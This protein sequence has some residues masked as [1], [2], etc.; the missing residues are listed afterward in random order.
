MTNTAELRD[1]LGNA[2]YSTIDESMTTTETATS[3]A[4]SVHGGDG[5]SAEDMAGLVAM[6]PAESTEAEDA[7]KGSKP[8]AT[9]PPWAASESNAAVTAAHP[10]G[11]EA[12]FGEKGGIR[13]VSLANAILQRVPLATDPGARLYSYNR[14]V[15]SLD[16]ERTVR[17]HT[18]DLLGDRYRPTHASL[19][20]SVITAR[21]PRISDDLITTR[22]INVANGL[23]DWKTGELHPHTPDVISINQL[24]VSWHPDATCPRITEWLR[25][26]MQADCL[27]L[28][29]EVLG[30]AIYPEL[31]WQKAVMLY[32]PGGNGKG[33]FLRLVESLTGRENVAN[34]GP[35]SLDEKRFA[36][37]EL[38]GKLV[39]IAGDVDPKA[40]KVTEMFKMVTGGDSITAEF[41]YGQPFRFVNRSLM[42]CSFNAFPRT[43][44]TSD[45]FFRRWVVL[46]FLYKIMNRDSSVED[47][48]HTTEELQGLLAM[49]VRGLQRL[50]RRGE[51]QEPASVREIT[52]EFKRKA[53]PVRSW[54]HDRTIGEEGHWLSRNLL[55]EDYQRWCTENGL[56]FPLA[57]AE[58]YSRLEAAGPE[59]LGTNV[60]RAKRKGAR[61]F[62][63]L[64]FRKPDEQRSLEDDDEE[65]MPD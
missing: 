45:G 9:L 43:A 44:D 58:F 40:F 48:M 17:A 29:E 36:A 23:L 14:G 18:I 62:A 51:F 39:N 30:A 41:K 28:V 56:N 32:G 52:A 8:G 3:P 34:T 11:D 57:A 24:P 37:A 38:H 42:L 55:Y 59:Q 20:E 2:Y 65:E 19:A 50:M 16:G 15:W 61:G 1:D 22:Y 5:P 31:P 25:T 47:A 26:I 54:L 60:R 13:S 35:Q 7:P 6:A 10:E 12:F 53:D 33:T 46:P 27:E 21:K 64:R 63:D 4:E 49:A